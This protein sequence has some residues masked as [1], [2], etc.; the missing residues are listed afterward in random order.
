MRSILRAILAVLL[1][2][3]GGAGDWTPAGISAG[4]HESCC[5]GTPARAEDRCA[6][7]KPED[8][9][10]STRSL[11]AERSATVA[12]PAARRTLGA[13]RIEP[14]PE[15]ATW[16]EAAEVP[17]TTASSGFE[18]GRDPDLGRHLARLSTF[19]I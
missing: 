9:R 11:C 12:S 15:P 19:R 8:N 3:G 7:P 6:C 5:C 2:L 16:A 13:R 18:H 1:L 4:T 10:G 14:R 17:G